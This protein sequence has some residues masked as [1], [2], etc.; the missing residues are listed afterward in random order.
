MEARRVILTRLISVSSHEETNDH[1]NVGNITRIMKS[2]E[3][4]AVVVLNDDIEVTVGLMHSMEKAFR[5]MWKM[6][7]SVIY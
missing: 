1:F 3:V 4:D 7:V 2:R 6:P 5:F